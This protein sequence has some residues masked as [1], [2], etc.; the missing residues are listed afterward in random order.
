VLFA[1]G[2]VNDIKGVSD[3]LSG[4][5]PGETTSMAGHNPPKSKMPCEP[6]RNTKMRSS[7]IFHK[8]NRPRQT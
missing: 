4:R 1:T 3:L 6:S 7:G 5:K 2:T 8:C